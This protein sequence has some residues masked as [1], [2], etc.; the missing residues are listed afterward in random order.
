[1][2]ARAFGSLAI[3]NKHDAVPIPFTG[4]FFRHPQDYGNHED[5]QEL[6]KQNVH[7]RPHTYLIS[8]ITT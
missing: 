2:M 4:H 1:M 3:N 5:K 6:T 8:I 7:L